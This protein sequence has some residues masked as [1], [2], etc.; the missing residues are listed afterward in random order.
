MNLSLAELRQQYPT[1]DRVYGQSPPLSIDGIAKLAPNLHLVDDRIEYLDGI[2]AE[3]YGRALTIS[4]VLREIPPEAVVDHIGEDVAAWLSIGSV[5]QGHNDAINRVLESKLGYDIGALN[6]ARL[7][8]WRKLGARP[9]KHVLAEYGLMQSMR[10]GALD[11]IDL[12]QLLHD[13]A[14]KDVELGAARISN[15]ELAPLELNS[16]GERIVGTPKNFNTRPSEGIWYDV[17]LDAP[18]GFMVTYKD[19]PH[20]MAAVAMETPVELM[21]HQLQGVNPKRIDTTLPRGEQIIGNISARGLAPLDWRKMMVDISEQLAL[22]N[23]ATSLGIQAGENNSWRRQ[24]SDGSD[25]HMTKEDG[26]RSYDAPARRLGFMLK[27]DDPVGNWHR[28]ISK[29]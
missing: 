19:V 24:G 7:W 28:D 27:Q 18:T 9:T 11:S 15:Y 20:A 29:V 12:P 5:V 26:E 6:T 23:N 25:P 3:D 4:E 8:Y 14:I 2:R 17:Y 13:N 22:Q 21:I 16:D 10:H 1:V